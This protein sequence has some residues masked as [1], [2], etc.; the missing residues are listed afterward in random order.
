MAFD[1]T[2]ST[3][4]LGFAL[5]ICLVGSVMVSTTA[6]VLRPKQ[7]ENRLID[8]Q[9]NIL[10]VAR[11]YE[12]GISVPEVF[13]ERIEA[14]VID[15]DS[16]DVLEGVDALSFDLESGG[17]TQLPT[18]QD[19]AGIKS[20]PLY[21][22]AYVVRDE[23]GAIEHFVIPVHGY[24][25]W[26]TMYALV[27]LEADGNTIT[28]IRYYQHG[29]TPGL[30]G[31]IENPRWTAQWEGKRIYDDEGQV[32]FRLGKSPAGAPEHHVDAL[33]GAT[34]TT[35]GVSNSIRYWFSDA[36]YKKYLDRVTRG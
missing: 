12:P 31:E 8:Q 18:D 17:V 2:S 1:K 30:G 9:V 28:A 32:A 13:A 10:R 4:A 11:L 26:S 7:Q 3:Y 22:L 23:A 35:L 19:I 33:S 5:A 36:G 15:F 6:V 21:G 25:L 20:R 16:G 24:G 29:E 34:L 14:Q 27:A